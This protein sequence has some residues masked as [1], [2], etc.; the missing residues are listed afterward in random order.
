MTY[1]D[2]QR[3]AAA[4]LGVRPTSVKTCWIAEIK[5]Q[6]GETRGPAPNR[7]RGRGAPPCPL[8]YGEAIRRELAR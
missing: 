6:R 7:G 5:R 3:K 8:E 4:L 1:A 2:I